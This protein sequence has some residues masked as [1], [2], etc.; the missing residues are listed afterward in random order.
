MREG[1]QNGPM[2]YK[3]NKNL[4]TLSD[5]VSHAYARKIRNSF[6]LYNFIYSS[7]QKGKRAEIEVSDEETLTSAYCQRPFRRHIEVLR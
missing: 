5:R 4:D 1:F 2:V 3:S 7:L 6:V